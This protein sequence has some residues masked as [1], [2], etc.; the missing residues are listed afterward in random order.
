MEEV[1][2]DL[3]DPVSK[4]EKSS[5]LQRLIGLIR[6]I[7]TIKRKSGSCTKAKEYSIRRLT[8]IVSTIPGGI[9]RYHHQQ[10]F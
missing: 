6:T 8:L 3:L 10:E 9:S 5:R 2:T 7:Y 4:L 1:S